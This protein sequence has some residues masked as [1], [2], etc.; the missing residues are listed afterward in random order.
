MKVWMSAA[1]LSCVLGCGSEGRNGGLAGGGRGIGGAGVDPPPD[2]SSASGSGGL[3]GGLDG[4]SDLAVP[5]STE[6]W[7]PDRASTSPSR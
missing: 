6:S 5:A 1:L 4:P 3:E 7:L 2:A